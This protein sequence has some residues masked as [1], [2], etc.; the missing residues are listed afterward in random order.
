M[1]ATLTRMSATTVM[2]ENISVFEGN[3]PQL[4]ITHFM[5]S[6]EPTWDEDSSDEEHPAILMVQVMGYNL[7]EQ[8]SGYQTNLA[9]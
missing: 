3:H 4:G 9:Y 1:G 6:Y 7:S 8:H 5:D 2:A